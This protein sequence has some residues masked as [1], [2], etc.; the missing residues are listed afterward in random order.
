MKAS[1]QKGIIM[2]SKTDVLLFSQPE[3]LANSVVILED[4]KYGLATM[5]DGIRLVVVAKE[6]DQRLSSFH[7]TTNTNRK[8]T[9]LIGPLTP[10]NAAALRTQIHWLKPSLLGIQTSAEWVIDLDWQHPD[11]YMQSRK[12]AAELLQFL[13][14][15]PCESW[16]APNEQHN[17][18]LMMLLGVFFKKT[19][20]TVTEL[21]QII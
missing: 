13:H 11:I 5:Q 6:G 14:N 15:N 10:E 16:H 1:N 9:Q 18:S 4:I 8:Q 12:W 21:M 20:V 7:G 3:L 17:K 2:K 19:G